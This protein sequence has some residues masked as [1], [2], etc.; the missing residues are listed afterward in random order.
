MLTIITKIF[1]VKVE[2]NVKSKLNFSDNFQFKIKLKKK[3]I[4][5]PLRLNCFL[6]I[7]LKKYV[8]EVSA[9]YN[10]FI[11]NNLC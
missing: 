1:Q 3:A 6:L 4:F 5:S 7:L 8:T 11:K 9:K 10:I 2:N